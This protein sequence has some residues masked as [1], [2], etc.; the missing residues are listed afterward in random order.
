MPDPAR[1]TCE[2]DEHEHGTC[3]ERDVL[4]RDREQVVETGRSEAPAELSREPAVV[5]EDDAQE[6]SSPLAVQADRHRPGDALA[7]PVGH[8]GRPAATTDHAPAIAAQ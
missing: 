3:D 8:R 6:N 7:Q 2:P 1:Q 5:A 4:A